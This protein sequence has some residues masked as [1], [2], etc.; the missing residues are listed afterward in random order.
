MMQSRRSSFFESVINTLSAFCL[1]LVVC[2]Y[3]LPVFGFETSWRDASIITLVFTAL[4]VIRNYIIR[5]VFVWIG[6]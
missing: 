1:S 4:S 5:R 3:L 6:W 2:R